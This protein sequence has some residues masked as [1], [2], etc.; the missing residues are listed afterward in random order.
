MK[1][2]LAIRQEI[3]A[4]PG[5]EFTVDLVQM[6]IDLS[7]A[8]R[9]V[10]RFLV[11]GQQNGDIRADIRPE[12]LL[13]AF[14]ILNRMHHDPNIRGLYKDVETLAVDIFTLYYY[15]ALS[16]HHREAGLPA[17]TVQPVSKDKSE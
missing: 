3:A 14:D 10:L 12:F 11:K 7:H 2:I 13:A 6:D 9:R 17:T 4:R 8:L 1:Q 16:I 15:G 5:P